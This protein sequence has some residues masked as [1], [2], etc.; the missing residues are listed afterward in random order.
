VIDFSPMMAILE[1]DPER[2]T[3]RVQPGTRWA[4]V[5]T[6]LE[7]YDLVPMTTP[8]SRFSTVAGWISTGGMGL[9][10]YAYGNVCESILSVRVA[11]PDGT[12]EELDAKSEA[13]KDLFG[14]EGQFGI[15]TEIT[16]RIRPKPEYSGPCL[17]TF[18]T[19]DQA[20]E[21]L[22]QLTTSNNHPSHVVF[23]DHEYMKRENTLFFEQT[24]MEE[25]IVS[26]Q[27]TVLLHFETPES[28]HKFLSSLN[29]KATQVSENWV[30]ARY[31]WS[32]R[33]FP[34]KA[35]RIGPGLLGSE[36]VIPQAKVSKYIT[37]ARRLARHFNIKPTIEVIVCRNG[38][39]Y[40]Y[41]VIASFSCDYSRSIHYAFSLLFIQLMVRMAVGCGGYPYGIGIW[42]TPF[43]G[44]KYNQG[45]LDKLKERKHELDPGETLN[46]NK[47]FKIKG[48]FFSIPALSL[49]PLTFRTIL[50]LAH[51]FWPV[52]GR[53]ARL[54]EPQQSIR[55]D[56][57]TKEDKQGKSLLSQ[58][59]Q[60]C[61]SCGSCISV[62]P[63]YYITQDELVIGRT[64][65]RMAEA[66]INGLKLEQSEVHEPF[67]CLHCGLCEEVCQTHLPLRDCYLVLEKWIVDRFGTPAE[68]VQRFIEELDSNR[69]FIKDIFGLDLPVWSPDEQLSRVPAVERSSKRQVI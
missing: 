64:K 56:V 45:Q 24:K 57:P 38:K 1:V 63:A 30:A 2:Q 54:V 4:D 58:C 46:P 6:K 32:D 36:V 67:Q 50:A 60:R 68:T 25:S 52:L 59:A 16:L 51:F 49:R 15:L 20:L 14:T 69:E 48:R 34:L 9:D 28:E 17:L 33:Y 5:A 65:L 40:S 11:R 12:I 47:F 66:M 10:S 26:E 62:C 35:Q 53:I 39:S 7:P 43:V 55:W 27:D 29:G 41:L 8:T 61:T 31:L 44:S 21:F 37:Q 19:P 3:I 13:I 22:E 42:N 18:N 23:F